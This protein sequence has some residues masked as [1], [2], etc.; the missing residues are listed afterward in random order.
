M[1]VMDGCEAAEKIK[2]L[3]YTWKISAYTGYNDL[4]KTC[5]NIKDLFDDVYIKAEGNISNILKSGVMPK[6]KPK[7]A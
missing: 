2:K 6:V 4:D 5:D 1:P 7:A 3:G